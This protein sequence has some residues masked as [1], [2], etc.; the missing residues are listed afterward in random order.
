MLNSIPVA[1]RESQD[2]LNISI[3]GDTGDSKK[4]FSYLTEINQIITGKETLN[5]L[6]Y[7]EEKLPDNKLKETPV[8]FV[9]YNNAHLRYAPSLITRCDTELFGISTPRFAIR[10][11]LNDGKSFIH[12]RRAGS[13]GQA[14]GHRS[15]SKRIIGDCI[16]AIPSTMENNGWFVIRTKLG[17]LFGEESDWD[18]LPFIRSDDQISGECTHAICYMATLI[19]HKHVSAAYGMAEMCAILSNGHQIPYRPFKLQDIL[20]YFARVGLSSL[21]QIVSNHIPFAKSMED[22]FL[23]VVEQY[24]RAGI[25][26]FLLVQ[27]DILSNNRM[28]GNSDHCVL[29]VGVN[30]RLKKILIHDPEDQPYTVVE[31]ANIEKAWLTASSKNGRGKIRSIWPI[32]PLKVR[33]PLYSYNTEDGNRV[34]GILDIDNVTDPTGVEYRLIKIEDSNSLNSFIGHVKANLVLHILTKIREGNEKRTPSWIWI[35]RR[36]ALNSADLEVTGWDAEKLTLHDTTLE[37]QKY[38]A[39]NPPLIFLPG[40]HS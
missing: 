5:C 4:H 30:L 37:P 26:C 13:V 23:F 21:P 2:A 9:N 40:D 8:A 10:L 32:L 29:I 22:N 34:L 28:S 18:C 31:Y 35:K 14:V 19:L 25:P 1:S 16:L 33:A 7:E 11:Y 38:L 3:F 24:I 15:T 17:A 6:E 36:G 12:L 39:E 27:E 20:E